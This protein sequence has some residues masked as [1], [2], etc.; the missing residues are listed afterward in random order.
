MGA[1][2]RPRRREAPIDAANAR[3]YA[4][5]D[6]GGR[7]DRPYRRFEY[8]SGVKVMPSYERPEAPDRGSPIWGN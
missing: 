8:P 3:I 5:G 7:H 4:S 2:L 6:D 1:V